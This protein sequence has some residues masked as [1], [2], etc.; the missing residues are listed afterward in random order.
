MKK[1]MTLIVSVFLAISL[2][3]CDTMSRQ[4]FGMISGGVAGGLLGNTI[5]GGTGKVIAIA[6]GT[7]AGAM[8]GGSIGQQMDA[9]DQSRMY[10]ALE[11]NNIGQPA[12]WHNAQTGAQ[13]E[14][15][16][17]RNVK[18]RGNRYC[19]EYRTYANI[20]GKRE[21]VYGKACRQPDGSWKA[22][23]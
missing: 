23:N 17:V 5:G 19:R 8:I 3:G 7:L 6:A 2:A 11:N 18:I 20:G 14:V 4:D 16:P 22:V 15:V 9:Q 21:Q 1:M 10:S 13:Y 12:Y